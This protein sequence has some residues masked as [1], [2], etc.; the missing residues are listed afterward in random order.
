MGPKMLLLKIVSW[1]CIGLVCL[2][3]VGFFLLLDVVELFEGLPHISW[4]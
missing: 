3:M 4:H 2:E 1:G